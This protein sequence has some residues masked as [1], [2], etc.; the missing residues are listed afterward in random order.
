MYLL[1]KTSHFAKPW[2]KS[3]KIVFIT[4]TPGQNIC[5]VGS[6]RS[7]GTDVE[8][9]DCN[10]VVDK[11]CPTMDMNTVQKRNCKEDHQVRNFS[12]ANDLGPMLGFQKYLRP[13]NG[14]KWRC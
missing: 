3:P 5:L 11:T 2:R 1:R 6:V 8:F 7:N 4:L 12:D 14:K 13:K 10:G 9:V